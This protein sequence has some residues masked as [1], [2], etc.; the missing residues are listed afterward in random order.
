MAKHFSISLIEAMD[1]SA[2]WGGLR[3]DKKSPG[4][5]ISAPSGNSFSSLLQKVRGYVARLMKACE[6]NNNENLQQSRC[7]TGLQAGLPL[8][9]SLSADAFQVTSRSTGRQAMLREMN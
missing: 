1:G 5:V 8:P 2:S 4:G 3:R 6:D 7:G 9:S